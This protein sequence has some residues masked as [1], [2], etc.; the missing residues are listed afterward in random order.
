MLHFHDTRTSHRAFLADHDT[1]GPPTYPAGRVC[2]DPACDAVLSIYNAFDLC[3]QC[4]QRHERQALENMVAGAI[5]EVIYGDPLPD[6][7]VV[8]GRALAGMAA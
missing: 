5:E 6:R 4:D 7:L 3:W 8:A 1:V 2:E